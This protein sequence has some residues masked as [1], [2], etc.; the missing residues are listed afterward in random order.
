[1]FYPSG[2]VLSGNGYSQPNITPTEPCTKGYGCDTPVDVNALN[3]L[4]MELQNTSDLEGIQIDCG[5]Q[6]N[7][8]DAICAI[9]ARK[10]C[11]EIT[12]RHFSQVIN[13]NSGNGTITLPTGNSWD[14][15]ATLWAGGDT[16]GLINSGNYLIF[17]RPDIELLQAE[18]DLSGTAMNIVGVDTM[19]VGSL[20]EFGRVTTGESGFLTSTK[21]QEGITYG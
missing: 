9:A 16:Q 11:E 15:D 3:G 20:T 12:D 1:M 17:E 2:G 14:V 4:L 8:Y 6:R 13:G 7:L 18:S 19:I 10:A 5:S 21:K